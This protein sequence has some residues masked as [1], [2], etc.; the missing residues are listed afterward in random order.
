[1]KTGGSQADMGHLADRARH[2]LIAFVPAYHLR[3]LQQL[4]RLSQIQAGEE[5]CCC[6]EVCMVFGPAQDLKLA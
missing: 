2:K 1:M 6:K 4:L 3:S 5:L